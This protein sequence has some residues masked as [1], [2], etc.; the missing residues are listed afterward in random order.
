MSATIAFDKVLDHIGTVLEADF[1]SHV[2]ILRAGMQNIE[3]EDVFLESC[4]RHRGR[5][6]ISDAR[7]LCLEFTNLGIVS[8]TGSRAVGLVHRRELHG[9]GWRTLLRYH[10]GM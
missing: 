4:L 6:L 2:I 5:Y 7:N 1:E 3:F 10:V 9:A 8:G